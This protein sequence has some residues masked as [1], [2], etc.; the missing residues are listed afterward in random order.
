MKPEFIIDISGG[1]GSPLEA[2]HSLSVLDPTLGRHTSQKFRPALGIYNISTSRVCSKIRKLCEKLEEYFN[3][4]KDRNILMKKETLRSEVIDYLE[5]SLYA[6]AE[7]VDDLKTIS[8][9]YF[10]SNKKYKSS[11]HASTFSRNIKKN[12]NLITAYIN[13]IKHQQSRLRLYSV[14]II[15]EKIHHCLHGYFIEGVHH[16]TI[17]PN[18]IFHTNS[19]RIFSI[20]SLIWEILCFILNS[21]RSLNIFLNEIFEIPSAMA[22]SKSNDFLKSIISA[23]RLPLYSFD[24][25]HPF[26]NTRIII[27]TSNTD[28]KTY[29]DSKIYGSIKEKWSKSVELEFLG[30]NCNYKGDGVS[31]QFE[32]AHPSSLKIQ[33]WD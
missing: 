20:T 19:K 3:I 26:N 24:D 31:K 29:F 25:T 9:Y 1:E 23:S 15:H 7:H 30:D 28:D 22:I 32:M 5:L 16:G 18:K 33:H 27:Q 4:S 14:E 21:S 11:K 10:G 8:K 2:L 6:A 12:K 13:A 17:G